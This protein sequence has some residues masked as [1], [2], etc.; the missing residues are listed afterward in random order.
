MV[1]TTAV[2]GKILEVD[3]EKHKVSFLDAEG[4]KK[5]VKVSKNLDVS[6]LQPGETVNAVLTESLIVEVTK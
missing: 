2:R 5:T 6:K 1:E 3:A 4:K